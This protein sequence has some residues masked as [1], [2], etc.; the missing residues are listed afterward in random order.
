MSVTTMS[1]A[2]EDTATEPKKK[3]KRKIIAVALVFAIGAAAWWFMLRPSESS[4]APQPGAVVTLEP[5][6]VN[7]A[8]G[9]YLR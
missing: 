8:A 9:H 1:G 7:L 6:Q 5:I 4:A 2:E 3:G